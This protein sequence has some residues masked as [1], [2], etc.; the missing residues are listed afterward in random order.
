MRCRRVNL[1]Y[2]WLKYLFCI[3][4]VSSSIWFSMAR[5]Y[6][7]W[8]EC[9]PGYKSKSTEGMRGLMFTSNICTSPVK[10][11][12][13]GCLLIETKRSKS[14]SDRCRRYGLEASSPLSIARGETTFLGGIR[15]RF[16]P[17]EVDHLDPRI[18]T[19][20]VHFLPAKRAQT[21]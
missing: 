14:E 7:T 15:F 2:F 16:A 20:R 13:L 18:P 5:Q 11:G 19:L 4:Y 6:S 17:G 1:P 21:R 12:L 3:I 9:K 10:T 8:N